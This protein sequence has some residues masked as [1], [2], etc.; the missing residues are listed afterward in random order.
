MRRDCAITRYATPFRD[1]L[2]PP[3]QP[4]RPMDSAF[5]LRRRRFRLMMILPMPPFAPP[6]ADIY[7]ILLPP[8][9][10][11]TLF[12]VDAVER[13]LTPRP[14]DAI[15]PALEL[16]HTTDGVYFHIAIVCLFSIRRDSSRYTSPPARCC[17][18]APPLFCCC[19]YAMAMPPIFSVCLV[20]P[21][22]ISPPYHRPF[23]R[24][25]LYFI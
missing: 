21:L 6:R 9:P 3:R 16:L 19:Q 20:M 7:D 4:M 11:S 23:S 12:E 14:P 15:T 2:A 25:T 22:A 24:R 5:M 8:P 18:F 17:R 1:D 10:L 13:L